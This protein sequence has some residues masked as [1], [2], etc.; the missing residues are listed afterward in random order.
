MMT[1][2]DMITPWTIYAV[3]KLDLLISLISAI[4]CIG[5]ALGVV[6]LFYSFSYDCNNDKRPVIWKWLKRLLGLWLVLLTLVVLLPSSKMLAAMLVLPRIA[7]NEAV[8]VEAKEFYDLAKEAMV[9]LTKD[10]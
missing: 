2:A 7:N 6:A 3:M 9:E 5:G 1:T 10:K 8:Q 4:I